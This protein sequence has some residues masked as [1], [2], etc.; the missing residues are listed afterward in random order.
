M[1]FLLFTILFLL[2]LNT[3]VQ[4]KERDELT[5][6]QKQFINLFYAVKKGKSVN[7]DSMQG[8]VLYP[9]L[10]YEKIR[11]NVGTVSNEELKHFIDQYRGSSLAD[12]L[13][14][15]LMA[16]FANK[17]LWS[18][19]KAIYV[20]GEGGIATRCYYLQALLVLNE[21][22]EATKKK[23]ETLWLSESNRPSHC[24]GL[25]KIMKAS[26]WLGSD[27]YWQRIDLAM[28]KG[29]TR[30]AK[31]L[32]K[33]LSAKDQQRV[34]L[35]VLFKH[36]AARY[37]KNKS[38]LKLLSGAHVYDQKILSYG[39]KRLAR[40]NTKKASQW[41]QHIE[42]TVPFNVENKAKTLSYIGMQ[43][44]LDH[45]P[46][47][48]QHLAAIPDQYR[49]DESNVWMARIA[50]RESDWGNVLKAVNAMSEEYQEKDVWR[51]W[52]ARAFS[53][54]KQTDKAL[55]LYEAL[56]KDASFYGFLAADRLS[57][58]YKSLALEEPDRRVQILALIKNNK[59]IQWALELFKIGWRNKAKREWFHSLKGVTKEDKL[60]AAQ[61]ALNENM[62]FV[63]IVS[64]AKTKD[65]NQVGLRFPLKFQRLIK[66]HARDN[67]VSSAWVY[68][69]T[70][71]E[72]AF[73]SN[74]ISSAKALGL[75]QLIPP[76]AKEVARKLSLPKLSKQDILAPYTNIQLGS[77]YL[78]ELLERF[79]GNYAKASAAYNAGPQRIPRWLPDHAL[80]AS[81]WIESIPF[82]ET[83]KYVRAVMSYTTIYDY[84]LNHKKGT[85]LRLSERLAT[86]TP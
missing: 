10:A 2:F 27:K 59:G 45:D 1:K 55:V 37:L 4:S 28:T 16:R 81:R 14:P 64:V 51:Y 68:G 15:S 11:R 21:S 41:L 35:W 17:G 5:E 26:G 22:V 69:V 23:A 13:W 12:S 61:L 72:S 70:R 78:K 77:A 83:R 18:E 54:D 73:D 75:M 43:N 53:A 30:L 86:I 85:N 33:Q 65:W 47:A 57:K 25:F 58:D 48:L 3:S 46:E 32:S 6:Q 63:A 29:K 7:I 39:I 52:K 79:N 76:T 38:T 9:L 71:R 80:E 67:D 8:Y 31:Q 20:L 66:K 60:A 24:N 84:K 49:D 19:V 42:K 40:K 44:A 50:L 36:K 82:Q 56:S 34:A 74:I 62:P